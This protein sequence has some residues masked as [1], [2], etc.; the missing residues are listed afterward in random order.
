MKMKTPK[1][2]EGISSLSDILIFSASALFFIIGIHQSFYHGISE[3][4]WLFMLSFGF[5][6]YNQLR[7]KKKE[8]EQHQKK[9]NRK[10]KRY[11]SKND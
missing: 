1:K 9:M 2:Q 4:Y 10:S 8:Q 6:L 3:S 5:I 11:V 7:K